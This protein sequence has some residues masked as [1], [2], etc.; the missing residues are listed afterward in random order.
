MEGIQVVLSDH[1][2]IIRGKKYICAHLP[3]T[4]LKTSPS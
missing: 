4:W 3:Y 2:A 1:K